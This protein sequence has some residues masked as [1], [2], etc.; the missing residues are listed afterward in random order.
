MHQ[1]ILSF[2]LFDFAAFTYSLITTER[3]EIITTAVTETATE[4]GRSFESTPDTLYGAPPIPNT[5]PPQLYGAPPAEK[6]EE[7][8]YGAAPPG[9]LDASYTAALPPPI[10][11]KVEK[12]R[13]S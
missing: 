11:T 6:T 5:E 13:L 7:H 12:V 8:G 3:P 9:T 10:P 2:S 1:Y 4:T